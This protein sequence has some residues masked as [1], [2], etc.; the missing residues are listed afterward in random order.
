MPFEYL[1]PMLYTRDLKET[2]AFYKDILGF[3]LDNF[4]EDLGW[5][6]IHNGGVK[7]MFCLPNEHIPFEKPVCTGSFYFYTN[8]VDELWEK[9]KN[10]ASILYGL[11]DFD[12]GMRE[13]AIKDNN[14]YVLQFG[15]EHQRN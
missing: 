6:H 11:E 4:S 1:T 13:F 8:Q 5:L 14:G 3:E 10:T 15:M 9:L 7:L 2:L 12:Y